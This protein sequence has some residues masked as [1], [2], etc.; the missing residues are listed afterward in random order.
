MTYSLRTFAVDNYMQHELGHIFGAQHPSQ[1]G[2]L[3]GGNMCKEAC[4]ARLDLDP[5]EINFILTRQLGFAAAVDL[6]WG[7]RQNIVTSTKFSEVSERHMIDSTVFTEEV[8]YN[9]SVKSI[10]TRSD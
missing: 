1:R 4:A 5:V 6:M 2:D 10:S 3:M 9:S 7:D 8:E